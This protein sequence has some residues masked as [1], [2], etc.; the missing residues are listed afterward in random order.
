MAVSEKIFYVLECKA[1]NCKAEFYL[2][3][4]PLA[5]RGEAWGHFFGAPVNEYILPGINTLT[6]VIGPGESP[7][8]ALRGPENGRQRLSA[9][10]QAHVSARL[11]TYPG[12]AI[13]GGPD[14]KELIA[15]QWHAEG[16]A[17][18]FFPL[19]R[20]VTTTIESP[21]GPWPWQEFEPVNLD[22]DTQAEI[23]EFV[24][25][26]HLAF[27]GAMPEPFIEASAHRFADV[28]RSSYLPDGDRRGEAETMLPKIMEDLTWD[29]QPLES[30]PP[31]LRLCAAG[32]MVE[33]IAMDWKP[34]LRSVPEQISDAV[35][36]FDMLIGKTEGA[37]VIVR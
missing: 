16:D 1:S 20:A 3:D 22:G 7:G 26:L 15:I 17:P 10:P 24:Q 25:Q 18:L 8:L 21:F 37:W 32:H 5:T 35:Y 36:Y 31:D 12:G 11:C 13:V 33:L 6:L 28:E 19:V 29:M 2:N 23:A 30:L 14:G 9:H 4:F 27:A 34:L